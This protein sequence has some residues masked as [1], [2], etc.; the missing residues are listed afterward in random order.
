[1]DD[2]NDF[3]GFQRNSSAAAGPSAAAGGPV[4][5]DTESGSGDSQRSFVSLLDSEISRVDD[6]PRSVLFRAGDEAS[7][8][9]YEGGM[10]VSDGELDFEEMAL[11]GSTTNSSSARFHKRSYTKLEVISSVQI[12]QIIYFFHIVI[13]IA[14]S[15]TV[16]SIIVS[17]TIFVT[18]SMFFITP[19]LLTEEELRLSR[20]LPFARFLD[21][22]DSGVIQGVVRAAATP[23]LEK[24]L[25]DYDEKECYMRGKGM[26]NILNE[27]TEGPVLDCKKG[28][29][30]CYKYW[31]CGMK[32][33]VR[34]DVPQ[35]EVAP[36][37]NRFAFAKI[38]LVV[39]ESWYKAIAHLQILIGGLLLLVLGTLFVIRLARTG[40]KNLSQE[41]L[42]AAALLFFSFM[43][44]NIPF[45]VM[46]LHVV[47][48]GGVEH[49]PNWLNRLEIPLKLMRDISLGPFVI[50]Y[51]WAAIH[52]YRIL[53]P[54]EKLGLSFYLPKLLLLA[55]YFLMKITAFFRNR[56]LYA[57]T[58][59]IPAI[60][61]VHTFR[62][63]K[64]WNAF[65]TLCIFTLVITLF[66]FMFFAIIIMQAIKTRRV[67][68]RA[69]YMKH[70]SKQIGFRFF[71]YLNFSYYATFFFLQVLLVVAR[72]NGEV[73]MSPVTSY[74]L[75][76]VPMVHTVGPILLT[77]G[78]VVIT[79]FINLPHDS[80]GTFKGWFVGTDLAPASSRWSSS[81]SSDSFTESS[82]MGSVD[83]SMSMSYPF[84]HQASG[85]QSPTFIVDKDYELNQEIVEPVTY[86]K[87]ESD[88]A[89]ELK[90]NCFTMQ[91][92]VIM[93]NFAWYVYYYGTP[94]FDNLR[95]SESVLP[96]KF[97]VAESIVEEATDTHALVIDGVDRIVVAFKGTTSMRN[98]KTSM[99]IYHERLINVVPTRLD[100]NNELQR[101]RV[102][103]G[104]SYEAAKIH[105]GF[106][107]AYASVAHR[108]MRRIKK[109]I[110]ERPRPVFL[111]GHS[112]GGALATICSLD[113]WIKLRISRRQIFVST[114][115]SPRVGNE[116]F[117]RIYNSVIALHWRIVVDP[118]MI[119][120]LPKVGYRHVGKKVLLT[121]FGEMFIDPSQLELKLWSGNTAGFAYHR[122]ASYLLAMRAWCVRHH[123][124]SYTPTFW[125]FPVHDEDYQRFENAHLQE[126][127]EVDDEQPTSSVAKKIILMDAM[128]DSLDDGAYLNSA[129][130]EKWARLT[131]RLLLR[132][133]L[134]NA[135]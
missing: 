71:I 104:R 81:A 17:N 83:N 108:V 132:H 97:S 91:T 59:F 93:F 29:D 103:F 12:Q 65:P 5:Y 27:W 118:D 50:F 47:L 134:S 58:P 77:F 76:M 10:P 106:A 60:V 92:H 130:I 119:A 3:G 98:L 35:N 31:P 100:A 24:P 70:R 128:V 75:L 36:T 105:K 131:R 6:A 38:R 109:L 15:W 115:G 19:A 49:F 48:G 101:L 54:A 40:R 90:A 62:G 84:M 114:F 61:L 45:A 73:L 123:K 80:V 78:Y 34:N 116:A 28:N 79:A 22:N 37:N 69:P 135:V 113:V 21:M 129:A 55:P 46:Q 63:Y 20:G 23:W 110:D 25:S 26:Y 112:L 95:P 86:R 122:K 32:I 121:A 4:Y 51:L 11:V 2:W 89:L 42:L 68:R 107:I 64:L 102:I 74:Q 1:M 39:P 82:D 126:D 85:Q 9:S 99:K 88:D 52:A 96:F 8:V 30:P 120:K 33:T 56:I 72:P 14:L 53:D 44:Y 94:K 127:P 43:Y 67:L 13:G 41:Q 16:F 87:R 133:K 117:R 18:E 57:E 125:P 124:M 111:T 66:E 7:E